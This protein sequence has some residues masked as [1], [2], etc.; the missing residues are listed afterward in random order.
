MRGN[1]VVRSLPWKRARLIIDRVGGIGKQ[2]LFL[3]IVTGVVTGV[4]AWMVAWVVV[5]MA[6]AMVL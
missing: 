6:G 2:G 3:V 5:I 1:W 4:V